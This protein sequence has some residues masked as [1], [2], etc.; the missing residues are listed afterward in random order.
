MASLSGVIADTTNTTAGSQ[1]L[2]TASSFDIASGTCDGLQLMHKFG[3]N[4]DVDIGTTEIV[5]SM[6][7]TRSAYQG[8][9]ELSSTVHVTS[10]SANDDAAGTHARK[11][12]IMGLDQNWDEASEEVTL[13]GNSDS[14][15]T[16]TRWLRVYRAY[17]TSAGAL[18]NSNDAVLT[19]ES[20][21]GEDMAEIPAGEGQ[22]QM[23]MYT[24]P[25]GKTAYLMDM[26]IAPNWPNP[27]AIGV[28]KRENTA[29][30]GDYQADRLIYNAPASVVGGSL[31]SSYGCA[32]LPE[33]TDIWAEATASANNTVIGFTMDIV[34]KDN[35]T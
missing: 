30:A 20:A 4:P 21:L 24:V 17:V 11:V 1:Y 9:L 5:S 35:V 26:H 31:A 27:C 12:M 19:V 13:V 33:R 3:Y 32:T 18:I 29:T 16:T 23:A 2:R 6:G 25:R 34:V 10:N 7:V 15:E 22:T 28:W 14:A 8:W